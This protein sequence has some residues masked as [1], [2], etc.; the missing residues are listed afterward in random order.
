[1][2]YSPFASG[3]KSGAAQ[4]AKFG[5]LQVGLP[6]QDI[7]RELVEYRLYD[8]KE[9]NVAFSRTKVTDHGA[10]GIEVSARDNSGPASKWLL[11]SRKWLKKYGDVPQ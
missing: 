7:T 3:R 10:T 6:D 2:D 4:S 11:S 5:A 1:M 8:G 9:S